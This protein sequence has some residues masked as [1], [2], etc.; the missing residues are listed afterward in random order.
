M[1]TLVTAVLASPAIASPKA[2]AESPCQPTICQT[3]S[4]SACGERT[5]TSP[6]LTPV[7]TQEARALGGAQR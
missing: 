2:K 6:L 1:S 4:V 7:L 3:P 5:P